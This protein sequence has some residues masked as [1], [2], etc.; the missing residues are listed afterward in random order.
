VDPLVIPKGHHH[1]FVL[2]PE[3]E[4]QDINLLQEKLLLS[5]NLHLKEI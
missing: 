2:A 4:Q 3:S 5:Q 1:Q